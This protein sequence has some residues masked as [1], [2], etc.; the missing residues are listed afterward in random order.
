MMFQATL[1][2]EG[3][4][5]TGI[6]VPD[7]VLAQLGGGKRPAVRVTLRGHTFATTIGSMRGVAMIPV[8]A[9]VRDASGVRAGDQLDVTIERD[10]APREVTVPD[11]LA[12]ALAAEPIARQ[13]YDKLSP[14]AK[15][16]YVTRIEE[17]K[18]PETRARRVEL[19]VQ[20]LAGAR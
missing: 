9:A 4:T 20:Q 3:K 16:A 8:S 18:K 11:D 19:T 1:L 2:L 14:S 10:T 15:K 6:A 5:A 7:E 13:A 12:A 17:A